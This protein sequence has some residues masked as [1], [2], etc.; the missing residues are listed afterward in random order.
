MLE[1]AAGELA[2]FREPQARK[3]QERVHD[4]CDH[5]RSA[6]DVKFGDILSGEALR[7]R[8]PKDQGLVDGLAPP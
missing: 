4:S 8:E 2:G 3:T 7:A 6:M 5:R 1:G